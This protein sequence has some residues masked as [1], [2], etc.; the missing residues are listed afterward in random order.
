VARLEVVPE[1][2]LDRV[3]DFRQLD[4]L[5]V[6]ALR[7]LVAQLRASRADALRLVQTLQ[8]VDLALLALAVRL[9]VRVLPFQRAFSSNNFALKLLSRRL[10]LLV[11]LLLVVVLDLPQDLLLHLL[12]Y[13]LLPLLLLLFLLLP[14]RVYL[15]LSLQQLQVLLVEV[16]FLH[17]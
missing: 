1:L 17:F 14:Y 6:A 12:L 15:L 16:L 4:R 7:L 8:G 13:L 11:L 3:V 9:L 5:R 10:L 2:L